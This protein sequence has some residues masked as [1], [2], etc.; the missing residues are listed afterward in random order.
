MEIYSRGKTDAII[1]I[2]FAELWILLLGQ[3]CDRQ[4]ARPRILPNCLLA[5]TALRWSA[6]G[7]AECYGD[8]W[9]PRQIDWGGGRKRKGSEKKNG[10]SHSHSS[11]LGTNNRSPYIPWITRLL[12]EETV[13]LVPAVYAYMDAFGGDT[14][15]ANRFSLAQVLLAGL[16]PR[17]FGT[18]LPVSSYFKFYG[19]NMNT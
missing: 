19:S 14:M 9:R 12:T 8:W 16:T 10:S 4:L 2:A 5:T 7:D 13:C 6:H 11:R 15:T 18:F 3:F 1:P 17:C